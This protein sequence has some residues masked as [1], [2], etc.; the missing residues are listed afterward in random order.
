RKEKRD[1][2]VKGEKVK[3]ARNKA[4]QERQDPKP[5]EDTGSDT[6][7]SKLPETPNLNEKVDTST[8]GVISSPEAGDVLKCEKL[9]KNAAE[10]WLGSPSSNVGLAGKVVDR[11]GDAGSSTTVPIFQQAPKVEPASLVATSS[12]GTITA[13]VSSKLF[14]EEVEAARNKTQLF[15]GDKHQIAKQEQVEQLKNQAADEKLEVH[16]VLS[17]S[18]VVQ[19]EQEQLQQQ[20][21][22]E[23][24][25]DV[26]AASSKASVE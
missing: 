21:K 6:S 14:S 25:S 4:G 5:K 12:P 22:V 3:S 17:T 8:T 15:L 18:S 2:S 19:M 24:A 16:P 11:L 10:S 1:T 26:A 20:T 13:V 23:T 9:Q 7:N